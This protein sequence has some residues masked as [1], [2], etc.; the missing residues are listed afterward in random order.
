MGKRLTEEEYD[1]RIAVHGLAVRIETFRGTKN[2]ILHKCLKHGEEHLAAPGHVLRGYGLYCCRRCLPGNSGA[3]EKYDREVAIHGKVKRLGDYMGNH[4]RILHTCLIH[5]EDYYDLPSNLRKGGVLPC[6]FKIE[7]QKT[8]TKIFNETQR[9]KEEEK[10]D[11]ILSLHG[12]VVRVGK[13]VNRKT[14]IE[15]KCLTHGEIYLGYPPSLIKGGSIA[16]CLSRIKKNKIAKEKY[17]N[18]LKIFGRVERLGEYID[19]KTPIEHRCLQHGE[20]HKATPSS[21]SSGQGLNCCSSYYNRSREAK[22]TYDE[23]VAQFGRVKRIEEY[24][25]ANK[26]ILHRC[27]IHNE[28]HYG[29]P[30]NIVNGGGLA[31]CRIRG[32]QSLYE[33]LTANPYRKTCFYSFSMSNFPDYIKIGISNRVKTRSKD[34]EYGELISQWDFDSRLEAYLVEQACLKDV[35][36]VKNSPKEL[37]KTKWPGHTEI[38]KS[39]ENLVVEVAQFYIDK[40]EELGPYQ[41]VLDYLSPNEKEKEI[42]LEKLKGGS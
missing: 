22:S 10:Y 19:C 21:L 39:E 9:R 4:K 27:L 20:V 42:C 35:L 1:K 15:H 38:V 28:I 14:K 23:R 41:F 34:P 11:N 5:N 16:C 31:C 17:D 29:T 32:Y 30:H 18:T 37:S 26:R 3:K 6:C 25:N 33:L 2:K 13:Y 24:K 12:R 36:L 40:L 7:D 8:P